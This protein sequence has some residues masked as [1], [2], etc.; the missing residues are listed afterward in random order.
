LVDKLTITGFVGNPRN[1]KTQLM[2]MQT[3]L[4]YLRGRKVYSYKLKPK[5]PKFPFEMINVNDIMEYELESGDLMLDEVHTLIDSRNP[6]QLTR[7]LSYFWSQSGKRDLNIWYTAQLDGSVDLRLRE[8]A[9]YV[10]KC[11]KTYSINRLARKKYI[12]GFKYYRVVDDELKSPKVVSIVKAKKYFD[13]YDTYQR[14]MPLELDATDTIDLKWVEEKADSC[15]NKRTFASILRGKYNFI[16][17]DDA[18]SV[19]DC[20]KNGM[21]QDALDILRIK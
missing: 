3:Y 15:Q 5:S 19:F 21:K 1:G 11:K 4:A 2:I 9:D 17:Y 8:I 7:L 6:S 18:G 16:G 20:L 12:T 14:I 13:L 10:F